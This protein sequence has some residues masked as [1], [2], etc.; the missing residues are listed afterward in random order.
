LIYSDAF[1]A[2]PADVKTATY[3]RL[4]EVLSGADH[5]SRYAFLTAADRQAILEILT[6]TK[7]DFA[8]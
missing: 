7:P 2:L 6:D 1:D 4:R 3:A 8:R 5:D